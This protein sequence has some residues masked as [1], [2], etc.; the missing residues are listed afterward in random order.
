MILSSNIPYSLGILRI[1]KG[2]CCYRAGGVARLRLL[3]YHSYEHYHIVIIAVV[4]ENKT[5]NKYLQTPICD[6]VLMICES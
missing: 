5:Q 3:I 6:N 1:W 2:G 4:I